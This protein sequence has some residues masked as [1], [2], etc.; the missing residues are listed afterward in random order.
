MDEEL[1]Y[2]RRVAHSSIY[3]E[4]KS[5]FVR[6]P[7]Y[8]CLPWP[9]VNGLVPER[10]TAIRLGVGDFRHLYLGLKL[11]LMYFR[12]WVDT[13]GDGSRIG[14]YHEWRRKKNMD[15]EDKESGLKS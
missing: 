7:W 13:C 9:L 8:I 3:R 11:A 6:K 12:W 14:S 5:L 15:E 4:K 1:F 10:N 2:L